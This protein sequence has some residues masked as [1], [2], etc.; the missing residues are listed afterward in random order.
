VKQKQLVYKKEYHEETNFMYSDDQ[1][2]FYI[3]SGKDGK[4]IPD[5]KS[6]LDTHFPI[7]TF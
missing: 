7:G 3:S 2:S 4:Y 6:K 5:M 1:R